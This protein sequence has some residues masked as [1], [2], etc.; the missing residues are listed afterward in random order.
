MQNAQRTFDAPLQ[1][2]DRIDF[3]PCIA[4]TPADTSD[5][6]CHKFVS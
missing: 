6:I 3:Y 5:S 1:R 2:K 4:D